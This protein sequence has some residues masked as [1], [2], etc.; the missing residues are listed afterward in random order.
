[1]KAKL[2]EKDPLGG[3]GGLG[4]ALQNLLGARR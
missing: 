2:A 3:L 4:G 1:M